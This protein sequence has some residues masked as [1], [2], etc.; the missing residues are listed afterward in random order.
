MDLYMRLWMT[1]VQKQTIKRASVMPLFRPI[2][3]VV[4]ITILLY[5]L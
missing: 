1:V 4:S 5:Y 3:I 2:K